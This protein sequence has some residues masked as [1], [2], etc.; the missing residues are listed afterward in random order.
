MFIIRRV[1]QIA[2]VFLLSIGL[3]IITLS[4]F[5]AQRYLLS[6]GAMVLCVVVCIKCGRADVFSPMMYSSIVLGYYTLGIINPFGLDVNHLGI[7]SD[8]Y[9]YVAY[10]VLAGLCAYY[11]G[12]W[13][14]TALKSP[15]RKE[16]T[17]FEPT[18]VMK[19]SLSC[20]F[21]GAV[22]SI[23]HYFRAGVPI[24][25]Q[26]SGAARR[27][28]ASSLSPWAFAQWTFLEIACVLGLYVY[29]STTKRLRSYG[30]VI[31]ILAVLIM[32]GIG[33]RVMIGTPL[34][35]AACVYHYAIRRL[36]PF[37]AALVGMG[38]MCLISLMWIWRKRVFLFEQGGGLGMTDEWGASTT[39]SF[40]QMLFAGLAVFARTSIES[41][42]V[43]VT[44][45]GGVFKGEISLMSFYAL[46]PGR[47]SEYGLY[48]MTRL[49]GGDPAFSGGSTVSLVGG[50]YGD[51][52][53][54]GILI[55]MLW[56]G[57]LLQW[58]N[59]TAKKSQSFEMILIYGVCVSYYLNMIYG[60]QFIDTSIVYRLVVLEAVLGMTCLWQNRKLAARYVVACS[61]VP[62]I[63]IF[64]TYK[65]FITGR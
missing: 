2:I 10:L 51:F 29:F 3:G 9:L 16:W 14:G 27:V 50:L 60:G 12:V 48:H 63:L 30:L 65:M 15:T 59:Q 33:S 24:L 58:L 52:G 11:L 64:A 22:F 62:P 19:A 17:R 61:M 45:G 56:L 46:A 4:G 20:L 40:L 41:F 8:V 25:A 5:S 55:G 31:A 39:G 32:L 36:R 53:F 57:A 49:L 21:I 34:I 42:A 26:D 38:A 54:L 23:P 1:T 28:F 6:G 43:L 35:I 7:S 18:A 13:I 44:L 37:R 47:Q